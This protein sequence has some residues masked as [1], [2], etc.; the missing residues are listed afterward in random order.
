[1]QDDGRDADS[2]QRRI[3]ASDAD[4]PRRRSATPQHT[5]LPQTHRY[6]TLCDAKLAVF[7]CLKRIRRRAPRAPAKTTAS[8]EAARRKARLESD[9]Q[10]AAR[11]RDLVGGG[12]VAEAALWAVKPKLRGAFTMWCA[13]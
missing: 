11:H 8:V 5:N 12:V 13:A 7:T 1:M 2:P 6:A 10:L 4:S 9:A 3:A